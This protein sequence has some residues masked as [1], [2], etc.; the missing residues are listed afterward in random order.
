MY[1]TAESSNWKVLKESPN[2]QISDIYPYPIRSLKTGKIISECHDDKGYIKCYL[3]RKSF[4]KHRIIANNFIDN[5]NE[6]Q[7]VVHIN[8]IKDDNHLENLKWW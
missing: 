7:T 1:T 6:L 4:K 2:H 3:N 8:G 5:P